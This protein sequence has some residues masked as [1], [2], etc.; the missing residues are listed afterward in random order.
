MNNMR[1]VHIIF[2]LMWFFNTS[3]A[4]GLK[5]FSIT[6]KCLPD[7]SWWGGISNDGVKMPLLDN[8]E[9]D[10]NGYLA[11]NQ[12]QPLLISNKGRYVWSETPLKIIYKNNTIFLVSDS[13]II[14]NDKGN[15]L[16]E[17][18][19]NISSSHFPASGK[20]PDPLLLANPQYNTW[21]EL[22]YNQNENDVLKY[23][24]S[25]IGN[26]FPT[27]VLMIDDTWQEDYGTW[28]FASE[29]FDSPEKMIDILHTMGFKVMLWVCPFVSS[30]SY[31][32]RELEMKNSLM[33]S[34][35]NKKNPAVVDWWNG[36][37]ALLDFSNPKGIVWF[38]KQLEDLVNIYGVDGF[39]F[40]AGDPNFYKNI[41]GKDDIH[42]NEHSELFA[43]MGLKYPFN[44]YRAC[45]KMGGQPLVQRLRDK[46]HSWGDLQMLIPNMLCLG[47][48]GYPFSC[49]D[50]IGG[51]NYKSFLD[52]KILDQ[53][54]IVR[55]AQV[56]ALMP[57]MQFSVAPWRV[58]SK[59]NLEICKKMA[60]LHHKMGKEI[61]SLA[62][63][64]AE[65]G[66]PIVRNMEYVFPQQG[67]DKI[68]DQFLLGDSVLVAPV[69][70]QGV[71]KRQVVLPEGNWRDEN[72]QF[73]S[74]GRSVDIDVPLERLP[75][76][77]RLSG[78]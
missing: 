1:I 68:K 25:I 48:S 62:K 38:E 51:G 41:Y 50:L 53:E 17:A 44:E 16:R 46:N 12:G 8:Y 4:D 27:G 39:K 11:E 64:S 49:P 78:Q 69:I 47:L 24:A 35:L 32:Y 55:S 13:Q 45:W 7:E 33:F 3:T 57:M 28:K 18:Y 10:Q 5:N 34:D 21:I 72:G 66:E 76:F 70:E 65:T 61:I 14:L 2:L 58:L 54:L 19:L 20:M 73:F 59:E 22:T 56:H 67:Y 71:R 43:R 26:G 9:F 75:W 40:D 29:R 42:P 36:K 77:R 23:A 31:V 6:L 74:G 30:D 37:S 60:L 63:L 15:T 52:D